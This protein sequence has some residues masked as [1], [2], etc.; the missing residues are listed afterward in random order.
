MAPRRHNLAF[1][2]THDA[3]AALS[4]CAAGAAMIDGFRPRDV[5]MPRAHAFD[6]RYEHETRAVPVQA[7]PPSQPLPQGRSLVARLRGLKLLMEAERGHLA[8]WMAA[9]HAVLS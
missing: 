9:S 8:A 5:A 3:K 1:T 4:T 2:K 7:S 6:L